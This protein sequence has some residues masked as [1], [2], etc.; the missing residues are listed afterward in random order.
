M[1]KQRGGMV[2][3]RHLDLLIPPTVLKPLWTPL[4]LSPVL[5]G[6]PPIMIPLLYLGC[7]HIRLF[8]FVP[9]TPGLSTLDRFQW[10]PWSSFFTLIL[11]SEDERHGRI[12]PYLLPYPIL[13]S[14][15]EWDRS[16]DDLR[17]G[18]EFSKWLYPLWL[19]TKR[20]FSSIMWHPGTPPVGWLPW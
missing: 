11:N 20:R 14:L 17:K 6:Q 15:L 16:D 4:K 5:K 10:R 13:P 3:P 12:G 7:F 8:P 1:V 19:L 2:P 9:F 18:G